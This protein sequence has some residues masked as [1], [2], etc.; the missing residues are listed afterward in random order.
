MDQSARKLI[1]MHKALHSSDDIDRIY[2]SRKEDFPA[3]KME[4]V[5]QNEESM[6]T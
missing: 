2:V 6:T 3:L 5:H 1:T 4:S